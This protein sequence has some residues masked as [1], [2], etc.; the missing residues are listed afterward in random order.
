MQ[1]KVGKWVLNEKRFSILE[2]ENEIELSPAAFKLLQ[3]LVLKSDEVVSISEIKKQVWN[4]EYT[5]DNLVYQTVR[6]LRLALE[7]GEE[8]AYIKTVPRFGYQL[9]VQVSHIAHGSNQDKSPSTAPHDI[10]KTPHNKVSIYKLMLTLII[11]SLIAICTYLWVHFKQ[12]HS[13]VSIQEGATNTPHLV[14]ID[15]GTHNNEK[16]LVVLHNKLASAL[17]ISDVI[18]AQNNTFLETVNDLGSQ[19]KLVI[20][21]LPEKDA[22][23]AL[24]MMGLPSRLIH[25][26]YQPLVKFD[27]HKVLSNIAGQ[28]TTPMLRQGNSGLA[29]L[30]RGSNELKALAALSESESIKNAIV[31]LR[32]EIDT[33]SLNEQQT[34]AKHA[35]I[36]TLL[37]FYRVEFI[38]DNKLQAGV[39]Y[40]LARYHQSNYSLIAAAL[41][42]ANNDN[43]HIAFQLLEK[44]EQ[45]H[46]LTFIQ[47]L[48]HIELDENDRALKHFEKVFKH[49]PEFEDNA[50]FY[51]LELLYSPRNEELRQYQTTL[52]SYPY[53]STSIDFVFANWFMMQ[54]DFEHVFTLLSE[55]QAA[56]S[57]N[58]DFAG[59][60]ALLNVV[61]GNF[62][63]SEYWAG[64]L[65]A[66]DWRL[67]WLAFSKHAYEKNLTTYPQWYQSYA[68]DILGG[69]SL[70]EAL[71]LN[72]T[73][74]LALGDKQQAMPF[75]SQMEKSLSRFSQEALLDLANVVTQVQ[76]ESL[77]MDE[78]VR[79]LSQHENAALAMPM[80]EIAL[81]DLVL[82]SFFVLYGDMSRA[83][84]AMIQGCNKSPVMCLSWGAFP[85][86]SRVANTNNVEQAK[87]Q[88]MAK[89]VELQPRINLL[90]KQL[91]GVCEED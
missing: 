52:Q 62:E 70:F 46:F 83:E 54:G 18:S 67:P 61:L 35:F 30:V 40:L 39:N 60:L 14:V 88:A 63:E 13:L 31:K 72:A 28:F 11:T 71:F 37:A 50:Y 81:T 55:R 43:G 33:S 7:G 19:P 9:I 76:V 68:P 53:L 36:N 74:Y 75:Y 65:P 29:E 4:T 85:L 32:L 38:E 69:D 78:R 84:Q 58:D 34:R 6:N 26:E 25:I 49:E 90:N 59:A 91:R 10:E 44:L 3:L 12:T 1:F 77:S 87:S 64:Q 5:T 23:L 48:L 41:Y 73:T 89:M 20:K 2:G 47:G 27:T 79:L 51:F 57:C 80:D 45:D 22:V 16:K 56:M 42:L 82:A 66:R 24:V 21:Y 15:S 86:L 17:N 8:Q